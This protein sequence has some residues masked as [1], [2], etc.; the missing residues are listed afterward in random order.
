MYDSQITVTAT[1]V[2]KTVSKLLLGNSNHVELGAFGCLGLWGNIREASVVAPM[3]T[4]FF[5]PVLSY[6][7]CIFMEN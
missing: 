5:V 1:E 7:M 6:S 2:S 3:Q 4:M